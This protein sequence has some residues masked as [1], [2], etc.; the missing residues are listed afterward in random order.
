MKF[1]IINF[2]CVQKHPYNDSI[3]VFCYLHFSSGRSEAKKPEIQLHSYFENSNIS[4]KDV[5]LNYIK[6]IKKVKIMRKKFSEINYSEHQF[7]FT[8]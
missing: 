1:E 5:T 3:L 2:N 6:S 8:H 7:G 4:N